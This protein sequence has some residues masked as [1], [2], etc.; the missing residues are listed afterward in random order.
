MSI[1]NNQPQKNN[2]TKNVKTS[3]VQTNPRTGQPMGPSIPNRNPNDILMP[4]PVMT[5]IPIDCPPGLEYLLSVDQV[6]IKQRVEIF[7]T[8]FGFE[9]NNSVYNSEQFGTECLLRQRME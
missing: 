1:N 2:Q 5:T 6:L 4:K 8:L 9:T 3:N 7:E